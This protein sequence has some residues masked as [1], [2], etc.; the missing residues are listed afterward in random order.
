M[1]F[2]CLSS[3]FLRAPCSR[4]RLEG[5]SLPLTNHLPSRF[6]AGVFSSSQGIWDFVRIMILWTNAPAA[7]PAFHPRWRLSFTDT[8]LLAM[9]SGTFLSKRPVAW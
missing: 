2:V 7:V 5:T 4:L 6:T 3:F 9:L 8:G 1:P